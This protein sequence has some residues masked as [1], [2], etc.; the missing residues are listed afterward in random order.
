M[1]ITTTI[2]ATIIIGN[3]DYSSRQLPQAS[4]TAIRR[5]VMRRHYQ[6]ALMHIHFISR[7]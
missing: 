6:A 5:S 4:T 3:S 1:F 2:A 7:Q